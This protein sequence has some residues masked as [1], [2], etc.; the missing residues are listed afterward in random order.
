MAQSRE[1]LRVV[2]ANP[3]SDMMLTALIG[4]RAL[5]CMAALDKPHYAS[6]TLMIRFS[7][8]CNS[9]IYDVITADK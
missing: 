5:T 8:R 6:N 2:L 7:T 9:L 4:P 1:V 3:A